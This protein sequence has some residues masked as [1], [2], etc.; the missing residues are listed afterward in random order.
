MHVPLRARACYVLT[1]PPLRCPRTTQTRNNNGSTPL[2]AAA[3]GGSME[4]VMLLLDRG[5]TVTAIDG[6]G[7]SCEALAASRGHDDLAEVLKK[8]HSAFDDAATNAANA[9]A[10]AAYA[11][12]A[13]DRRDAIPIISPVEKVIADGL[14]SLA[15]EEDIVGA[16]PSPEVSAAEHDAA[17]GQPA[18]GQPAKGNKGHSELEVKLGKVERKVRLDRLYSS[19]PPLKIKPRVYF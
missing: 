8:R 12:A 13:A 1:L 7:R 9:V 6:E 5:A 3:A 16:E 11:A 10:A 15:I 4:S 2:H 17:K 14:V 19:R 18:K